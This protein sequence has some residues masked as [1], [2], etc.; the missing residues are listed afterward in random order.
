MSCAQS[1]GA[2]CASD[3]RI[4]FGAGPAD[5]EMLDDEQ[6]RERAAERDRRIDDADPTATGNSA[7]ELCQVRLAQL[8]AIDDHEERQNRHQQSR[9]TKSATRRARGGSSATAMVTFMCS[10]EP[11]AGG[12]AVRTSSTMVS[13]T[14]V[15]LRPGRGAVEHVAGIDRPRD[16]CGNQHQCGAGKPHADEIGLVHELAIEAAIFHSG[17]QARACRWRPLP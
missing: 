3:M 15:G 4:G 11:V 5:G 17:R 2:A 16:D 9:Q 7:M 13:S 12:G 10:A 14:A 1:N 8:D 6:Q